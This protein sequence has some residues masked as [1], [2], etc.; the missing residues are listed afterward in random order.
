MTRAGGLAGGPGE[1]HGLPPIVGSLFS[2]KSL[3]TNRKTRD[4]CEHKSIMLIYHRAI[5]IDR[6]GLA[7]F[8]TAASPRSTSLTLLLGLGASA[9][10]TGS[11]RRRLLA[12]LEIQQKRLLLEVQK[13]TDLPGDVRGLVDY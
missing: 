2:W 11:F 12:T 7:T 9:I 10:F 8:P 4:D 13:S 6:R 5:E 1:E 3:L